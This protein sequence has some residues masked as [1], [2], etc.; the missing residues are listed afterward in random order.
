M[1]WSACSL[2]I[3][4]GFNKFLPLEHEYINTYLEYRKDFGGANKILIA[5]KQKEGDIFSKE[6][7]S[8]LKDITDTVFFIDG[9]ERSSVK[10]LYTPNVRFTEV[11]EDGISGG[12]IIPNDFKPSSENFEQVRR[13]IQKSNYLGRLVA[14]DFTASPDQC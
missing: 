3:D 10:S 4:V 2:R 12:N 1:L 11:V 6:F 9:V 14:H 7:F 13:N 5:L 8:A